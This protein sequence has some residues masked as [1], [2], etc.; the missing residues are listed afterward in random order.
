[1]VALLHQARRKNGASEKAK[2]RVKDETQIIWYRC[3]ELA[4]VTGVIV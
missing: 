3:N 2:H 1:M 4:V